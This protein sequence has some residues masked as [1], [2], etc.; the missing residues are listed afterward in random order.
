ML[1]NFINQEFKVKSNKGLT[2]AE[3]EE[4]FKIVQL[5]GSSLLPE[6]FFFVG[7]LPLQSYIDNRKEI[8]T[9]I[10]CPPERENLVRSL[11]LRDH[12]ESIGCTFEDLRRTHSEANLGD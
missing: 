9:G 2:A 5:M 4:Q 11:L 8:K 10:K 1:S 12:L 3:E 6:E 7:F